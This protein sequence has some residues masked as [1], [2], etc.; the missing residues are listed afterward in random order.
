MIRFQSEE[1][2]LPDFD[3]AHITDWIN[4]IASIHQKIVGEINYVVC[5]DKKI[6]EYNQQ[7]LNHDYYT[8][9]ITFDYSHEHLVSGDIYVGIE[10]VTSNAM[11]RHLDPEKEFLRVLIHGILHLIGFKDK[12]AEDELIMH[13]QEDIALSYL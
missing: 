11:E 3:Q 12:T 4:R 10:T 9:I 8:D 1:I 13:E 2:T 7:W 5:S 6:L